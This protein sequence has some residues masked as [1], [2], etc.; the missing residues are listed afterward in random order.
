[1]AVSREESVSL[2]RCSKCSNGIPFWKYAFHFKNAA[3]DCP[4]CGQPYPSRELGTR[5]RVIVLFGLL[6][7]HRILFRALFPEVQ[8]VSLVGAL[9]LTLSATYV[10]VMY[11]DFRIRFA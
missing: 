7:F 3:F 2:L 4:H 6:L 10:L 5:G 1:M 9:A 11:V 8:G